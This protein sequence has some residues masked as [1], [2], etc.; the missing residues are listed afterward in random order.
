MH[1]DVS[2][3]SFLQSRLDCYMSLSVPYA[4]KVRLKVEKIQSPSMERF[5]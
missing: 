4:I 2:L 1:V 3:L 5:S